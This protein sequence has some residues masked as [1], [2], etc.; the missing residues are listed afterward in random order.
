[1]LWWP[2][3]VVHLFPRPPPHPPTTTTT[4]P[5]PCVLLAQAVSEYTDRVDILAYSQKEQRIIDQIKD[6]CSILS[7]LLVSS[8]YRAGQRLITAK[9]FEDNGEFFQDLFEIARR[10]KV[11]VSAFVYGLC[12]VWQ[13][14]CRGGE[15]RV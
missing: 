9:G 10:H 6:M 8:D 12:V 2:L 14:A 3:L 5:A 13:Y 7:G 11:C 4:T 1:M 15:S